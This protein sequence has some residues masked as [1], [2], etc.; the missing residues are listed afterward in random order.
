[1]ILLEKLLAG[2]EVTVEPFAVCDVRGDAHLAFGPSEDATVHYTLAG[3]GVVYV[4]NRATAAPRHTF[5]VI[6]PGL[7]QRIEPLAGG[8]G[9]PLPATT[10]E[11]LADGLERLAAGTGDHGV[12]LACGKIRAIF[13]GVHGLFDYLREPIVENFADDDPIRGAFESLLA[14]LAAPQPGAAA[15]SEALMKQCLVLLLRRHCASGECRVAWLSALEDARLAAAVAAMLE[16]PASPFTV[17]RLAD[18][19]GMSRSA[20]AQRF[21]EVFDRPPMD[22]L[23]EIRLRHAARLLCSSNLPVKAVANSVGYASRSYFS[24]AFKA[25]YGTD[26]AGFRAAGTPA[27]SAPQGVR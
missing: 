26:P 12:V 5:M 6:P 9:E 7:H 10:C 1:M 27:T 20:F 13:R 15:L 4:G 24:R 3:A 25:F 22:F 16:A 17:E 11:P 19:A 23:R 18:I 14:E 2:L 21:A 8:A